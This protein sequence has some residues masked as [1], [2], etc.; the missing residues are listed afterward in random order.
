MANKNQSF[1]PD[2]AQFA[3][4]AGFPYSDWHVLYL[5]TKSG[6]ELSEDQQK[7]YETGLH[8]GSKLY[9]Q[10]LDLEAKTKLKE[11]EQELNI[12]EE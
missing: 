9:N 5:A 7:K 1:H 8:I 4:E 11:R 6:E 10:S 12:K 3:S 2:E